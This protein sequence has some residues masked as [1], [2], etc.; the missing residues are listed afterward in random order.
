MAVTNRMIVLMALILGST[1]LR[2][3]PYTT[4]GRVDDPGPETNEVMTKSSNDIVNAN[5]A[6]DRMPGQSW[7]TVIF[8]KVVI[9]SAPRIMAASSRF[10]SIPWSRASTTMTTKEIQKA[11]WAMV[12]VVRPSGNLS[13]AKRRSREIPV[14]ISG[15]TIGTYKNPSNARRP[16]NRCRASASASRVPSTAEMTVAA[17]PTMRLALRPR[18]MSGRSQSRW[19]HWRVKPRQSTENFESLNEK[20]TSTKIGRWRKKYTTAVRPMSQ[21]GSGVL[22]SRFYPR[23]GVLDS[24]VPHHSSEHQSHD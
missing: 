1:F 4:T 13:S 15:V 16:R 9:S 23:A 5:R 7:G 20:T 18:R 21:R 22:I 6:P 3:M 11:T 17:E 14:T 19:Y 12:M 8:Q 10:S 2:T 24:Q